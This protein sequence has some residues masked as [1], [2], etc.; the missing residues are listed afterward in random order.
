MVAYSP[1]YKLSEHWRWI[2]FTPEDPD[3]Q[4]QDTVTIKGSLLW[5]CSIMKGP[6]DCISRIHSLIP[7]PRKLEKAAAALSTA[8]SRREKERVPEKLACLSHANLYPQELL[9]P[10]SWVPQALNLVDEIWTG[11]ACKGVWPNQ[12]T[13]LSAEAIGSHQK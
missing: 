10:M 4:E 13:N 6:E 2:S 12:T 3:V 5:F 9:A 11:N 7:Y 1:W 8:K